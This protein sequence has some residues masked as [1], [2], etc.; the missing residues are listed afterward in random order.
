MAITKKV[1]QHMT[2]IQETLNTPSWD[3]EEVLHIQPSMDRLDDTYGRWPRVWHP[4]G[5]WEEEKNIQ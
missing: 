4:L 1:G 2:L 3:N 5:N